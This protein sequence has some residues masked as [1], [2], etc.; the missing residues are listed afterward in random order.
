MQNIRCF[1]AIQYP[2]DVRQRIEAYQK[3]IRTCFPDRSVG[4]ISASN[5]HLTLKFYGELSNPQLDRLNCI[6][7]KIVNER[8]GF[9][10]QATGSGVFP[11]PDRARI[12]W[13]GS[14]PCPQLTNLAVYVDSFSKDLNVEPEKRLFSPHLTIGRIRDGFEKSA[15]QSAV[16]EFL[17][18]PAGNMGIIPVEKIVLM[19]SELNPTGARYT[20]IKEFFLNGITDNHA[21]LC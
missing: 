14:T 12:L 8:T 13:I 17:N 21:G 10:F 6:L 7:E 18:H 1:L 5:L 3:S 4:W 19:R 11:N 15:I 2:P 20:P 16:K 9:T